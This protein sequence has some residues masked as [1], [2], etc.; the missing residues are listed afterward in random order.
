MTLTISVGV[1][2]G[3]A[4]GTA[5]G[6]VVGEAVGCGVAVAAGVG[7]AD[8]GAVVGGIYEGEELPPPPLHPAN[9]A[10]NTANSAAFGILRMVPV[11]PSPSGAGK[12]QLVECAALRTSI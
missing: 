2:E 8:G 10:M 3:D 7:V 11:P 1:A 6:C 4:L 5:V 9:A 12:L